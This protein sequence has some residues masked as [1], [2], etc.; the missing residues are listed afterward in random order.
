MMKKI[1]LAVFIFSTTFCFGQ[2]ITIIPAPV[3]LETKE[4]NFQLNTKTVIVVKDDELKHSANFL[5]DYLKKFYCFSLKV[6]KQAKK[7]YIELSV[8]TFIKAPDKPE[9]YALSVD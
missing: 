7:N 8:L 3:K 5:N 6:S 2:S 9:Q 4:G 1:L